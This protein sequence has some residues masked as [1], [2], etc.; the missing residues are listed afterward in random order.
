MGNASLRPWIETPRTILPLGRASILWAH[1]RGNPSRA[2]IGA[3][4]LGRTRRRGRE[5]RGIGVAV[6]M[7]AF[8][9]GDRRFESDM[10]YTFARRSTMLP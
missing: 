1:G 8:Q 7:L 3:W 4:L 2:S 10:P 5:H 9:A 6:N